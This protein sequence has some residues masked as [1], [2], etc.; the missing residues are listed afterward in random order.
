MVITIDNKVGRL[1]ELRQTGKVTIAD[2]HASF[3]RFQEIMA[4]HSGPVVL[5]TDWRGMRLLDRETSDFL[6]DIM[7]SDEG[8]HAQVV[9]T[10][11]SALMGLQ[12]R[13]LFQAGGGKHRAVYD[14]LERAERFLKGH[15]TAAELAAFRSFIASYDPRS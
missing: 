2:L 8:V 15:V 10:D 4:K 6:L 9:I 1:V 11:E 5:A 3:P 7:K 13:R 14:D 12:I